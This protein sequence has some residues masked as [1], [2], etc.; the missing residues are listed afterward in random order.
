MRDSTLFLLASAATLASAGR[1][2]CLYTRSSEFANTSPC[3]DVAALSYCLSHLDVLPTAIQSETERCF[4]WAGCTASE[5]TTEAARVLGECDHPTNELKLIRRQFI[6]PE[7]GSAHDAASLPAAVKDSHLVLGR[8]AAAAPFPITGVP[9][10]PRADSPPTGSPA[11][12]FSQET[13]ETTACPIITTGTESGRRGECVPTVLVNDKCIEGLICAADERGRVNCM[14]KHSQLDLAG[15]ILAIVF[16]SAIVISIIAIC[17]MCCRERSQ[18]RKIARE[19]EAAKIAKEAKM[20]AAVAGKRPGANVTQQPN[21]EGQPLM[22]Q[23]AAGAPAAGPA[24]GAYPPQGQYGQPEQG[25]YG[26]QNPFA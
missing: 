8:A 15:I 16:A 17:V 14:Y 22:Y 4:V 18:H 1:L 2:E 24:G 26:G 19:A 20:Q 25:P 12:C 13:T 23:G 21:V 5:A 6:S 10:R 7:G 3:G 11:Q 9:H